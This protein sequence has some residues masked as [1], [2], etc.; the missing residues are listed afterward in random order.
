MTHL[1]PYETV[2]LNIKILLKMRKTKLF[3]TSD[4]ISKF[5]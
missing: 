4:R 2:K 1:K 3:L 5:Y